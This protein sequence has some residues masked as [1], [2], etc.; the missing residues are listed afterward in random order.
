[1][2]MSKL[3]SP[4]TDSLASLLASLPERQRRKILAGLTKAERQRV[5]FLWPFWARP[6]QI[7]PPGTWRTWLILAGRAFGKTR[8]GAEYVR[9]A[10]EGERACRVALVAATAADA[11]DVIVEGESG[12]LAVSPPWNKPVYEPSKRRLT[13]PSGAIA[14]LYSADDRHDR[15]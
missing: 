12:I 2:Q 3:E 11:R 15:R 1:M 7:A 6:K 5:E 13:W 4:T 14:T 10:I 8:T 9:A